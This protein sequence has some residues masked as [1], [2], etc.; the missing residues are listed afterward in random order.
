MQQI[1]RTINQLVD[2]ANL[3]YEVNKNIE[4]GHT[5]IAIVPTKMD[6][7]DLSIV[8]QYKIIMNDCRY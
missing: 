1:K 5:I 2:A 4:Y 6:Q 8:R 7:I 3:D